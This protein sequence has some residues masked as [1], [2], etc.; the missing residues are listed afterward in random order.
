MLI[1]GNL[2]LMSPMF[3]IHVV[4]FS[5]CSSFGWG[6]GL[7][8]YYMMS[9]GKA[10]INKLSSTIHETAEAV[11]KLQSELNKQKSMPCDQILSSDGNRNAINTMQKPVAEQVH[12]E[13]CSLRKYPIETRVTSHLFDSDYASSVLTEEQQREGTEMEQLE[14]E[15]ES[16]LQKLPWCTTEASEPITNLNNLA[17]VRI[18]QI[19]HIVLCVMKNSS[20]LCRHVNHF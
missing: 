18:L 9:A 16:E 3:L 7:G 5:D 8:M 10:E 14:A 17:Q 19:A 4:D 6:L 11:P 1:F 13:A 20:V 15:L 12:L 2:F